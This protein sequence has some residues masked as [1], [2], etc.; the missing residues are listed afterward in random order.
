MDEYL[1]GVRLRESA[2]ADDYKVVDVVAR[3]G[4]LVLVETAAEPV[5]GEVRRPRRPVPEHKRDQLYRRVVRLATDEERHDYFERR[6]DE[7]RSVTTAQNLARARN[8]AMKVVDV[9][10][11]PTARRVTVYFGSEERIDFRDL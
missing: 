11:H 9:E 7:K 2:P 4:D 8:L 5:V 1:I 10:W 6:E 3:V